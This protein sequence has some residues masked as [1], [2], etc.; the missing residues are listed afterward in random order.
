MENIGE[1]A[2]VTPNDSPVIFLLLC[3]YGNVG[4]SVVAPLFPGW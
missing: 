3:R 4:S 1:Y 2:D